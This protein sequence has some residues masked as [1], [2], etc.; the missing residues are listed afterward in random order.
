MDEPREVDLDLDLGEETPSS[1]KASASVDKENPS[2]PEN[3]PTSSRSKMKLKC[4]YGQALESDSSDSETDEVNSDNLEGGFRII[5]LSILQEQ[6]L[7]DLVCRHCHS[8][9]RLVEEKRS[10]LGSIFRFEC[11]GKRCS[12]NKSFY[13]DPV[14][15]ANKQ[16]GGL[17]NHSINRRSALAM[18]YIGCGHSA[19]R[20]FCGIMNLPPPVGNTSYDKIKSSIN[21]AVTATQAESMKEAAK[22]EHS[23]AEE[24][25]TDG[26]D[27]SRD[28]D[29]SVDGTYMTRGFSSKAGVVTAIGCVTGKV[30]DTSV[31]SK[32]C[33]SCDHWSKKKESHPAEYENWLKSHPPL[34]EAT[35]DGSSG[36]MEAKSAV[37]IFARSLENNNLRY[38]RYIGDGD[39]NSFK[40]VLDSKPYMDKEIEKIECVGHVQKRMGTRLRKLKSS[41]SGKKLA[42]GKGMAGAGRLTDSRI[43]EIQSY[44]GNA[45]RGNKKDIRGMREAIW[46]IYFHK[47]STDKA[48]RHQLCK[49][50]WCK[51]RQ[52]EE[53]GASAL[54]A[55]RHKNSMPEAIMEVIKPIFKDLTHPDLLNKCLDG[56]TQNANES[57][58]Q[59]IWKICPKNGYHG[60]KTI[61][62]AVGLATITFN[63]G[64]KS[65][66]KVLVRL[67]ISCGGF[68]TD[69]FRTEDSKRIKNAEIRKTEASLEYRRQKR[70]QKLASDEQKEDWAYLR[71]GHAFK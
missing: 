17:V 4:L 61:R 26:S 58:N 28:V 19:L 56:Y 36:S 35:H 53:K 27:T 67:G 9:T 30:L 60:A 6:I 41:M 39:T 45:I 62:T 51:Y 40:S 23:L 38:T 69:F 68:A 14:T 34:C 13:S 54:K 25:E 64:M 16:S 31:R 22:I 15:K 52:A 18:R 44:F 7:S 8:T 3:V 20:T 48:P 24:S 10:G 1:S 66:E 65:F 55:F 21:Q 43:D 29:V 50:E 57:V 12:V 11:D 2:H 37:D 5:D 71:G 32:V 49:K 59:K 47:L 63:D 42:D 70:R 33:K 46:A